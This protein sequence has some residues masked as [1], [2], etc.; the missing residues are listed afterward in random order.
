M[1]ILQMLIAQFIYQILMRFYFQV[2]RGHLLVKPGQ[3][4]GG[5]ILY[6]LN[7]GLTRQEIEMARAWTMLHAASCDNRD[8]DG[9]DSW[10][11]GHLFV[12]RPRDDGKGFHYSKA[13]LCP[14]C[15]TSHSLSVG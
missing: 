4:A 6:P 3:S 2:V 11:W 7:F 10:G 8:K 13:V 14:A 12:E 9:L 5:Q 1:I 15:M